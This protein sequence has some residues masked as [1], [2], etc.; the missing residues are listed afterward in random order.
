MWFSATVL[1][2]LGLS[3]DMTVMKVVQLGVQLVRSVMSNTS[4]LG[5]VLAM[6]SLKGGL[7]VD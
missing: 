3:S 6:S 1:G 4:F 7:Q 5:M 2:E